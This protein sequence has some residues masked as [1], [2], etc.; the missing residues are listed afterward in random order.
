MSKIIIVLLSMTLIFP[1]NEGLNVGEVLRYEAFFSNIN[2]GEGSL[3]IF[4][5]EKI[6]DNETTAL[7]LLGAIE[8]LQYL[9]PHTPEG[10]AEEAPGTPS[11]VETTE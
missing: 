7:K 10:Q 6:R 3:K 4:G 2:A 9:Y 1:L 5:I 11:S 8:T